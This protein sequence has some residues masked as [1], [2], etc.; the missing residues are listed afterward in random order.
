MNCPDCGYDRVSRGD[1]FCPNCGVEISEVPELS[2]QVMVTQ[3]VG[4]VE[5]GKVTGVDIRQIVGDVFVDFHGKGEAR[6]RRNKRIL[7]EKVRSFW[8]EGV[9]ERSVHNAVLIDLGKEEIPGVVD[10]PWDMILQ[11]PNR[12]RNAIPMG[13]KILDI[14]DEMGRS[15]LILGVPGSGKTITLLELARDAI[16]RAEQDSNCPIPVVFNL[17]SW[18]ERRLSLA[19]WLVDELNIKYQIPKSIGKT[20][21]QDNDLLLLL[22]GL[23]EVKS[24]HQVAC[25][26]A[27]NRFRQ[28]YGLTDIVICSRIQEYEAL[29]TRLWLQGAIVL[30]PPTLEQIDD[31]LVAGGPKLAILR[32]ALHY[33]VSL[34]EL[35]RSPLVLS[36]MGL[37]YQD[38]PG[39]ALTDTSFNSIEAR[40]DHLFSAYVQHMFKRRRADNPYTPQQ[41][42]RWLARLSQEMT[43]SAQSPFLLEK[44]QSSWLSS[45]IQRWLYALGVV[46]IAGL[47]VG[48]LLGV[49]AWLPIM[50]SDGRTAGRTFGIAIGLASVV[51][52]GL[53]ARRLFGISGG[54][55]VGLAFGLAFGVPFSM[56]FG[57]VNNGRSIGFAVGLVV[58]LTYWFV[59][60]LLSRRS[61]AHRDEIEIV[62]KLSWSWP[63]AIL[64]L[65]VGFI[66][67]LAFGLAV[68]QAIQGDFFIPHFRLP[69]GIAFGIAAG[70][71]V[72]VFIGFSGREVE[73]STTPNQ[74]IWRSAQN[75]ARIGLSAWLAV[76]MPIGITSELAWRLALGPDNSRIVGLVVGLTIGLALGLAVSLVF[77]GLA[78]VQH[79]VLRLLL[80]LSGKTPWKYI[81]FLDYA[82]ERVFLQKVGG[83]YIF[84]HRLLQE[85][86]AQLEP[87]H[88][89]EKAV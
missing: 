87:E 88:M 34:Q 13:T 70:L 62:E 10:H 56:Y 46:V 81:R 83:G 2:A 35:A 4:G 63:K 74:G 68:W 45:R 59:G 73:M 52:I 76:A 53:A 86:F 14:F 55:V 80:C 7:L 89:E 24:E 71:I 49:G 37:A 32:E 47:P 26:E 15:L 58:G 67:G 60:G 3:S 65:F 38:I 66:P 61:A 20:W 85:Y 1:R 48:L 78:C 39:E 28:E 17:S 5:S 72:G 44:M 42:V 50:L 12:Q 43:R 9:L 54:L 41:T 75:A 21:I 36:I 18:V 6:D 8:I 51:S 40:R 23:D 25:A 29:T 82:A 77:G 57:L 33:D 11:I 27:I 84:V 22:D 30:Q 79:L 31:Y 16:T 19:D 64:G 69:F